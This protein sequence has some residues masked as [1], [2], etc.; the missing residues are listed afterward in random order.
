MFWAWTQLGH[1]CAVEL[2]CIAQTRVPYLPMGLAWRQGYCILM[3]HWD[4]SEARPQSW[5]SLVPSVTPFSPGRGA[6]LSSLSCT[7][8]IVGAKDLTGLLCSTSQYEHLCLP[9]SKYKKSIGWCLKN[10]GFPGYFH[11]RVLCIK[12]TLCCVPYNAYLHNCVASALTHNLDF[13]SWQKEGEKCTLFLNLSLSISFCST[14]RSHLINSHIL[15]YKFH[16][17]WF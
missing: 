10:C 4:S 5:G 7:R 6:S 11:L 15:K 12:P 17:C 13:F 9:I 16:V 3:P 1:A 14:H 2:V 8:A